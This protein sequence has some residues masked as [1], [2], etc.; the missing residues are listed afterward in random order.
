MIIVATMAVIILTAT[1]ALFSPTPKSK[2]SFNV[3]NSLKV[4]KQNLFLH[5]DDPTGWGHTLARSENDPEI[6]CIRNGTDCSGYDGLKSPIRQIQDVGDDPYLE[7]LGAATKGISLDGKQCDTYDPVNGNPACP[8]KI[9]ITWTP[10]CTGA[11]CINPPYLVEVNF[12]YAIPPSYG[13]NLDVSKY[14]F[15]LTKP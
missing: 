1:M 6:I 14:S 15:A 9:T 11:P 2:Y 4:I 10:K 8:I 7:G 13:P 5:M 3:H 12:S